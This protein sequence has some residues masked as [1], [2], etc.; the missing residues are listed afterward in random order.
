MRG[1][2]FT[3]GLSAEAIDF[4]TKAGTLARGRS[5]FAEATAHLRRGLELLPTLPESEGRAAKELPIQIA[6]GVTHMA[7]R[8][9]ASVEAAEAYSRARDICEQINDTDRLLG[10]LI[11]LRHL[12]Q[13]QGRCVA[14]RDCGSQCL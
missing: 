10:V 2:F 6:L 3:E 13:V 5:A 14:T 8:G 1:W 11:G 9:Y 7:T 12:N 4:W